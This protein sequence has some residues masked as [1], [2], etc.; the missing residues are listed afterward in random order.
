MNQM[1]AIS[2]L[3]EEKKNENIKLKAFFASLSLHILLFALVLFSLPQQ[4]KIP[5][6]ETKI[7]TIS[8]AHFT[9][10]SAVL[11]KE[12]KQEILKPKTQPQ[13]KKRHNQAKTK[14]VQT[15]QQTPLERV[16]KVLSAEAFT[17]PE[18][19]VS[20]QPH[21]VLT[22]NTDAKFSDSPQKN[23]SEIPSELPSPLESN[24]QISPTTLGLIRAMIEN[25]LVYPAMA[26]KLKLEGVVVV[27]FV[28]TR[29]GYVENAAIT[30]KSGSSSLDTKA[31]HTVLSLSGEYPTVHKNV[32]LQIPIAFSL[33]KS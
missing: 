17:P 30:T 20:T 4:L 21:E 14:K 33:K 10:S 13:P 24:S 9:P 18:P 16:E 28:L 26:K 7:L 1:S 12:K 2:F 15:S 8:L 32:Q 22:Q 27:S 23:L 3:R 11:Q 25:A 31:L 29:E 19:L 6:P 5:L